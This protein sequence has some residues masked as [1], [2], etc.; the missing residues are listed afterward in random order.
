[1]IQRSVRPFSLNCSAFWIPAQGRD[2]RQGEGRDDKEKNSNFTVPNQQVPFCGPRQERG[3]AYFCNKLV[4]FCRS[5]ALSVP[6][7]CFNRS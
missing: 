6:L 1:V 5:S 3:P 7:A 4:M 2:D